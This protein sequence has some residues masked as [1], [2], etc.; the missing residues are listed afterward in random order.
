MAFLGLFGR[1]DWGDHPLADPRAAKATFDQL[2]SRGGTDDPAAVLEEISA[3]LEPLP[4]AADVP[5][6]RRVELVLQLDEV[7]AAPARLLARDYLLGGTDRGRAF[8]CWKAAE[9]YWR[10]LIAA[11]EDALERCRTAGAARPPLLP[12][13]LLHAHAVLFKW[14]LF[15]YEPVPGRFWQSAGETYLD[16]EAAGDARQGFN[17]YAN[18]PGSTSIEQEYLRLLVLQGAAMDSLQPLEIEL[19][20]RLLGHFLPLF[21]LTAEPHPDN[22]Y[23]VDGHQ[24]QPPSRLL[25]PPVATPGLRFFRTGAAAQALDMLRARI[26]QTGTVPADL[27]LGGQYPAPTVLRVLEHLARSCAPT[28]P[29]RGHER[30]GVRF[31]LAVVHGREEVLLRLE[32][33]AGTQDGETWVSEDVSQGGLRA[34]VSLAGRDWLRVGTLVGLRPER[35]DVWWV[36]VVRR[37]NRD[38][39]GVGAVG[40]ETLGR[41]P[42]KVAMQ[43]E[44]LEFPAV[45]LESP[46][47]LGGEALLLLAPAAW[48]AR[49]TVRISADGFSAKLRPDAE[50][51]RGE[52]YLVGRYR[53]LELA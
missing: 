12:A 39:P 9:G 10:L 49:G 45:L 13:R 8:R 46:P 27:P 40:V 36:G 33:E 24:A 44:G 47:V 42:R 15:R 38:S 7:G 2:A 29:Q 17:L 5:A 43:S 19:A 6:A 11:G 34:Q 53:V 37:F 30:H 23:W 21:V 22:V 4:T 28:P 25:R 51:A 18:W 1:K 16:A 35:S 50:L 52:D 3:W 31:L 48:E 32:R 41:N 20:E 26:A 14:H